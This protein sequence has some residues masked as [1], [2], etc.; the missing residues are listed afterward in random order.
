MSHLSV[1]VIGVS[2][3]SSLKQVKP[4]YISYA[5]FFIIDTLSPG[6]IFLYILAELL[7]C[8]FPF[9]KEFIQFLEYQQKSLIFF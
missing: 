5:T 2:I 1:G 3:I 7:C 6:I 9:D 4:I 8:Y